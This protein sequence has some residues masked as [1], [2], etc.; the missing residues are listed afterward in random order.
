MGRVGA[1]H[2]VRGA[3]RVRPESADPA[4]LAAY[5]EWLIRRRGGDWTAHRVDD[6]R[7]QRDFLVAQLAGIATREA[8]SALRGAEVGVPRESLPPLEEGEYYQADLVG[9]TVVN[10][11]GIVLGTLREFVE[12]GAHPIA[13]VATDDGRECLIPWVASYIDHVDA[14]AGRIAIDW[15]ANV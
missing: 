14:N 6:V 10:R 11:E 5:G 12:S 7:E 2:G 3:F 9:M 13:R 1:P 8:A 4:T 15:P